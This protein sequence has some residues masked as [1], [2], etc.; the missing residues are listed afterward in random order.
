MNARKSIRATGGNIDW[1]YPGRNELTSYTI[2]RQTYCPR[3][4]AGLARVKLERQG[5]F[6]AWER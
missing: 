1:I 5:A 6:I 3:V 2:D 4:V